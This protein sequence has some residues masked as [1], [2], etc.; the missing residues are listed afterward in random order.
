M[1]QV[2]GQ[3][4]QIQGLNSGTGCF[5]VV[6]AHKYAHRNV[7]VR[8]KGNMN[9]KPTSVLV[10]QIVFA[11]I[12]VGSLGLVTHTDTVA[13]AQDVFFPLSSYL[14][15]HSTYTRSKQ[16]ISW[17]VNPGGMAGKDAWTHVQEDGGVAN[18]GMSISFKLC[19]YYM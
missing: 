19:I 4:Q 2:P 12:I 8:P 6:G 13:A 3:Q 7:D 16:I 9:D 17:W 11:D 18:W 10:K 14:Y 5:P 15:P 1:P